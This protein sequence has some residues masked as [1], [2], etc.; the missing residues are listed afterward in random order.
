MMIFEPVD[1]F[2]SIIRILQVLHDYDHIYEKQSGFILLVV[3]TK[4]NL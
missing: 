3:K 1:N 2:L 4:I